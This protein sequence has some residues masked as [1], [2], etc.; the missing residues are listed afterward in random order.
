MKTPWYKSTAGI[1]VLLFLFFPAGL[2]LMWKYSAWKMWLKIGLTAIAAI[3]VISIVSSSGSN[4]TQTSKPTASTV[5]ETNNKAEAQQA[6]ATPIPTSKP[7]TLQDKLWQVADSLHFEHDA[8]KISY[9]V[10]TGE[11]MVTYNVAKHWSDTHLGD[12]TP[13]SLL[14]SE[15]NEYVP[16]AGKM[17]KLDG[18]KIVGIDFQTMFDDQYGKSTLQD[19]WKF[20]M[21]KDEFNKYDWQNLDG[22]PIFDQLVGN[23]VRDDDYYIDTSIQA[24]LNEAGHDQ[25]KL[26]KIT[27]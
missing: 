26:G 17:F 7:L 25:V 2:F 14:N 27:W 4:S 5:S 24:A 1:I 21:T 6:T 8:T 20:S 16:M 19:A 23:S 11:V 13:V 18:V 3:F 15:L 12:L 22:K 10:Q 9:N